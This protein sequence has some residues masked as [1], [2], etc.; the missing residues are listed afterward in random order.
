MKKVT[1]HKIEKGTGRVLQLFYGMSKPVEGLT[2]N[3]AKTAATFQVV[4]VTKAGGSYFTI[5][6]KKTGE[7]TS[8]YY[9]CG[10]EK[11]DMLED[12]VA[13]IDPDANIII[14]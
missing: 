7:R 4:E 10:P 12:Y 6:N 13:E 8:V 11:Y 9:G 5:L 1:I 2:P 14:I 3:S